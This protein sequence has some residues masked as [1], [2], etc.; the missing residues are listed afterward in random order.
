MTDFDR[1]RLYY[2]I[3]DEKN[4]LVNSSSGRLEYA[5]TMHILHQY[6]PEGSTIL[7]LGGGAG[8]YA[9]PLAKE[10]HQVY[11]ADLSKDLIQEAV[12]LK[13]ETECENLMSCDVVNALDL[14]IYNDRQF[15][16]VLLLGPLYHLLEESER[17]QCVSEVRRVLHPNGMVFAA[18][19][20]YLSGSIGV[21]DRYS[22]HP[23]QVN[24]DNLKQVF[25]SGRFQNL[26]NA[27][28]QEGYYPTSDEIEV[29]FHTHGFRK[30]L[31]RSVRS[32]GYGR[33][34]AIYRMK[35]ENPEM[36]ETVMELLNETAENKAIVEMC[37]HAI[38]VGSK[39]EWAAAY[40]N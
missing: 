32:F 34:D 38:Y 11:L 13:A 2:K 31:T 9:F 39:Q 5:M 21:V 24:I 27:G 16:V 33:E 3:F 19:I 30:L 7:D 37:G 35:E 40:T 22:W 28:F 4:R 1:I 26:A 20:P 17:Q 14:G 12:Q 15:D 6:L 36:F 25:R 10:G 18:F 8:A 23:N 29:L